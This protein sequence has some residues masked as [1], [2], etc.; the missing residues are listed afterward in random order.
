[1]KKEK[2]IYRDAAL[3]RKIICGEA[4]DLEKNE[5]EKRIKENPDLEEVYKQIQDKS[6]LQSHFE[7]YRKYSWEKAYVRFLQQ[8]QDKSKPSR[9]LPIRRRWAVASI[10][11]VAVLLIS[12]S[13]L[14]YYQSKT[15]TELHTNVIN[16]GTKKAKL[17]LGDGGIIDVDKQKVDMIVDGVRVR[18]REGVLSYEPTNDTRLQTKE[19]AK[20]AS[21]ANELFIPRG[22]ENTLILSD[23][24][25][26]RL[27]A[28]S[29]LTYPIRFTGDRRVVTLEGE[30][31]FDVS[32]DEKHPFVVQT[33]FGEIVALGT[34]FNVS[35]Y[36]DAETCY[37]TLIEG[38]VQLSTLDKQTLI[39]LPG[40]QAIISNGEIQKKLV[41]IKESI[42]WVTGVYSFDNQS[43]GDIMTTFEKWYDIDVHYE[44][45]ALQQITYSG[46]IKR[47]NTINVFLEAL[48]LTGDLG[49]KI[50]GKNIWIYNKK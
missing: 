27:N 8:I 44:V 36:N 29:K 25:K 50:E 14:H 21:Q 7:N 47:Y 3:I 10:A 13:T 12:F 18:Y 37:T 43:L 30:A 34:S 4:N 42:G 45:P 5:F 9:V 24:T 38:K 40:E 11:V 19:S 15:Q 22:G 35:A 49:Y 6:Y 23:G 39:L 41:Q 46:N 28:S 26:V 17:S 16:P 31:Y 2:D 20:A 48:E 32:K 33:R 1:M